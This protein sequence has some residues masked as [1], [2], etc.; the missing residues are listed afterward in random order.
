MALKWI[1][2][3]ISNFG[4]DHEN[5][6]I[7]GESAGAASVHYLCISP[8]AKGKF[9]LAFGGFFLI[10]NLSL[11]LF[12]RTFQQGDLSKWRCFKFVGMYSFKSEKICI[13]I[14]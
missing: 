1:R 10:T 7:F 5:I 12:G 8:L 6:T 3:N 9:I 2:E 13:Q 11:D 14:M 4:G